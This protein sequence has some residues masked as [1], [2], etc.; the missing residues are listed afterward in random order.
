MS[1]PTVDDLAAMLDEEWAALRNAL[2]KAYVASD[3]DAALDTARPRIERA[4]AA[5]APLLTLDWEALDRIADLGTRDD[6]PMT[7]AE[8]IGIARAALPPNGARSDTR[9]DGR[10][11]SVRGSGDPAYEPSVAPSRRNWADIKRDKGV[12]WSRCH[13]HCSPDHDG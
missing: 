13:V 6:W 12:V 2:S 7:A 11:G 9:G 1:E 3:I 5:V 10:S 8:A 4:A